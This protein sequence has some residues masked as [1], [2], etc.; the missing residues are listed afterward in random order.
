MT[1]TRRTPLTIGLGVV[2]VVLVGGGIAAAVTLNGNDSGPSEDKRVET[3]L[4]DFYTALSTGGASQAVGKTCASDRAQYDAYT[5]AQKKAMDQGRVSM[6]VDSVQGITITGDRATAV[7]LGTFSV[8]GAADSK[9]STNEHLR[10]EDGVW[11][12]CSSDAK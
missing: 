4:R 3:A 11:K 1:S 6:R 12:V 7:T 5:D 8:P 2:A 10:K 9:R